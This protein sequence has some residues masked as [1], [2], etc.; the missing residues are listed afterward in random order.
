MG[1]EY[2]SRKSH[3][4]CVLFQANEYWCFEGAADARCTAC[5]VFVTSVSLVSDIVAVTIAADAVA[6]DG[7][8]IVA[9]VDAPVAEVCEESVSF[10]DSVKEL[11]DSNAGPQE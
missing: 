1:K 2:R 11:E 4:C 6:V 5:A 9:E 10:A 8:A 7:E 3:G